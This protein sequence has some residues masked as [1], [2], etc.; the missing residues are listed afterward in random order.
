VGEYLHAVQLLVNHI[1]EQAEAILQLYRT[2]MESPER[3]TPEMAAFVADRLEAAAATVK[4]MQGD[5]Q[6]ANAEGLDKVEA[7]FQA[8]FEQH[9]D[10]L[11]DER[12]RRLG[13]LPPE[14][15]EDNQ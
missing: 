8:L 7:E 1:V 13:L 3:P 14:L 12:K 4:F 11:T 5:F 2:M 9:A 6:H 10:T 15:P